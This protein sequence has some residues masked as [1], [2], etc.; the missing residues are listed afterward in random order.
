MWE[1][2]QAVLTSDNF[3]KSVIGVGALIILF[4]V[5]AKE[6]LISFKGH[7]LSVG[8]AESERTIV[9]Q[10]IEYVRTQTEIMANQLINASSDADEWRIRY[11]CELVEDIWIDT[12]SYNHISKDSFYIQN[13]FDKVWAIVLREAATEQFRDEKF[14][15]HI[16]NACKEVIDRLVDIKEYY[17]K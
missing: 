17:S 3:W 6:G 12:I 7:G 14:K 16:M 10:Q 9:R 11:I 13:K 1:A 15:N 8:T 4:A 2:I 5:L